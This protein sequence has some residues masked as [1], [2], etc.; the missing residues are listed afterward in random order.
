[1][2]RDADALPPAAGPVL[3]LFESRVFYF[4]RPVI[5][6]NNLVNWATLETLLS[7]GGCLPARVAPYVVINWGTLDWVVQRV[8][9][10]VA[11]RQRLR[12]FAAKCLRQIGAEAEYGL[13]RTA[14]VPSGGR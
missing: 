3:M 13:Y 6:D 7:P 2:T 10:A 11:Q 9:S 14:G 4:R 5:P 12:A 1:V 8:P